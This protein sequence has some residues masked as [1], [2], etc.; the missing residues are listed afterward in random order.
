VSAT[1]IRKPRNHSRLART[2]AICVVSEARLTRESLSAVVKLCE[3]R[4]VESKTIN[5]A[6]LEVTS[7]SRMSDADLLSSL[8]QA[9]TWLQTA[10]NQ[11]RTTRMFLERAIERAE[12]LVR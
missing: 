3:R 1:A 10:E 5:D 6:G 11:M 7:W 9:L 4:S 12:R 8:Y 2:A